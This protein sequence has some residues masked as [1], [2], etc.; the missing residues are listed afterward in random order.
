MAPNVSFSD[1]QSANYKQVSITRGDDG[2]HQYVWTHDG[3]T[4]TAYRDGV[5]LEN[6]QHVPG[7]LG[8]KFPERTAVWTRFACTL[9]NDPAFKGA[10]D[11][12]RVEK[13]V[14]SAAWIKA[15]YDNQ[16]GGLVSVGD[17]VAPGMLLIVR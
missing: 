10:L 17:T 7:V 9:S 2:W 3:F 12:Y 8:G 14:R 13:T 1:N 16:A 5:K 4:L 11:E 6:G 15:C